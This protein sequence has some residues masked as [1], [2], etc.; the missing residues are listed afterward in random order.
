LSLEVA[1]ADDIS[2]PGI[3]AQFPAIRCGGAG[4]IKLHQVGTVRRRWPVLAPRLVEERFPTTTANGDAVAYDQ[5]I[6]SK[7]R[8]NLVSS[9]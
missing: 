2:Q 9:I 1:I 4:H 6:G 3:D 5:A 7:N 8:Q